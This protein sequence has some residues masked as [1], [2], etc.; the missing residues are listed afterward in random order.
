MLMLKILIVDSDT[1]YTHPCRSFLEQ[2]GYES[3][4]ASCSQEVWDILEQQHIDLVV[5]ELQL[6]D[7]NPLPY[8]TALRELYP[9]LPLLVVTHVNDFNAKKFSFGLGADEYLTKPISP[10]ELFL[11]IKAL[12]RRCHITM[13]RTLTI[14]HTQLDYDSLSLTTGGQTQLLPHKEFLLL[15]KLASYP[16]KIFPRMQLLDEIWGKE[17]NSVPQ[18][19]DVH[20]NRLR[21]RLNGNQDFQ[22]VT[23]RGIGYKLDCR[24]IPVVA[25]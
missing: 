1:A 14:G 20:I 4:I 5:T 18:T 11:H 2:Q 19:V 13:Q 6:P 22:I 25:L 9:R 8:L 17:S 16:G 23:V 10:E 12:L 24:G 15:F 7:A 3:L 21:K